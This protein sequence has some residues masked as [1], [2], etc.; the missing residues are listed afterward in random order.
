M[1]EC[2][3]REILVAR[4]AS[5]SL[6]R[7]HW[8]EIQPL[9]CIAQFNFTMYNNNALILYASSAY[10]WAHLIYLH[11]AK[12]TVQAQQQQTEKE[13]KNTRVNTHT[14]WMKEKKLRKK[15]MKWIRK[16]NNPTYNNVHTNGRKNIEKREDKRKMIAK[17]KCVCV[18]VAGSARA[19]R[20]LCLL[21][22]LF[23]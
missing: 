10:F 18:C 3:L 12:F 14:P 1:S 17:V 23:G 11:C 16:N 6:F 20:I 5:L 15:G 19:S 7:S 9:H 21:Y 22:W 4:I 8:H 2:A 13:P